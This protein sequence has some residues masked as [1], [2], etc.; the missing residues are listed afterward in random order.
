MKFQPVGVD[1][2]ISTLDVIRG[3]SLLGILLVNM[4]GFYL[5]MPHIYDL[6]YWFTE[7]K[8]II[9]HQ[10]LDIYVQSSFYPLFSMLFGYG[11]AMQYMKAQ[12]TE[13]N[14]YKFAP[15][16]LGILFFIGLLHAFF[17]WWGDIL[18]TYAF[19]GLFL[20]LLIRFSSGGLIAAA[21]ALNLLFHAYFLYMYAVFGLLTQPVEQP[22]VDL[23]SIQNAITA[24]GT[25]T[26]TDAF[27]QRLADLAVQLS[28]LAWVASLLTILPYM[29][30]GAAA[31]KWKLIERAKEKVWIWLV[32]AVAG[33]GL[34]LFIKNAPILFTRTYLLDYLK[35]YVGGPIL[36][37]GYIA[38]IVLVCL[39]PFAV[40]I[41]SPIAK[42]GRMSL[43]LYIMQSIVCT[44]LFY[45]FGFSLYGQVDV[46]MGVYIALGIYVVQ[47]VIAELWLS[48]FTQ[49]P[50]EV[51]VKKLTYGKMLSEK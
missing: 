38:V 21:I 51:A 1:E 13:D 42:A 4:F 25:G 7:A 47:L 27:M 30:I 33:V 49:G 5:P 26:W 19:C 37:I 22:A 9:Q 36:S 48:K 35:V 44:I 11:L 24:Y 29:L 39:V 32:L 17:I 20:L 15:R 34:G 41:L 6:S 23:T 50:L 31:A 40:K 43:T 10:L 45:H 12:R 28:P 8:D 16:R 18:A 2:R 46:A 14:F 3:F